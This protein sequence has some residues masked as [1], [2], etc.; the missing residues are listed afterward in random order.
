MKVRF[1]GAAVS[2]E[3]RQETMK[4]QQDPKIRAHAEQCEKD[5]KLG[6][7]IFTNLNNN[8]LEGAVSAAE[9]SLKKCMDMSD[10]CAWQLAPV[11]VNNAVM[12]A[13]QAQQQQQ[14]PPMQETTV[15]TGKKAEPAAKAAPKMAL[16]HIS[17]QF[18]FGRIASLSRW[19]TAS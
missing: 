4:K 7:K 3:C 18:E 16:M 2:K 17:F 12:H 10:T 1:S 11:V 9:H 6:E 8:D 14:G 19:Q 5:E 13:M 15:L